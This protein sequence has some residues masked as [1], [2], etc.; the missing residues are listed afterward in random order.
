MNVRSEKRLLS[1]CSR[2]KPKNKVAGRSCH[3][4]PKNMT[5]QNPVDTGSSFKSLIYVTN[6]IILDYNLN[7][8]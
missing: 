2:Q 4:G 3:T 7:S 6:L 5:P 8:Q 1:F